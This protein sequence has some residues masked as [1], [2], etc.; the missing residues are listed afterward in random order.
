V[1]GTNVGDVYVT[2]YG[3]P[4][5]VRVNS[6]QF[7][8][9][10]A[11][12]QISEVMTW[13]RT[14]TDEE[15]LSVVNYITGKMANDTEYATPPYI[16]ASTNTAGIG[17]SCGDIPE[18]RFESLWS[19]I[20]GRTHV[21]VVDGRV[22]F[23]VTGRGGGINIIFVNSADLPASGDLTEATAG[24]ELFIGGSNESVIHASSCLGCAPSSDA[25]TP[26]VNDVIAAG[27]FSGLYVT[28]N[29][30]TISVFT[31]KFGDA[32]SAQVFE[33]DFGTT[34][35]VDRAIFSHGY[36]DLECTK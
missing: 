24:V 4:G 12:F 20:N 18:V 11:Y 3:H 31:G 17:L 7:H 9:Q 33:Y 2:R 30:S 6:G 36:G 27:A 8:T 10:K 32:S 29:G 5:D 14:L 1:N 25:I 23:E 26:L 21:D 16:S 15:K 22:A 19:N 28:I 34:L 35:S 13:S